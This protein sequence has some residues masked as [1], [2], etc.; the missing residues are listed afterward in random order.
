VEGSSDLVASAAYQPEAAA[1]AAARRFVRETLQSWLAAEHAPDGRGLVDDAVLLTSELVTNAV[2]HAGTPVQVTCKLADGGLEVMVRD[3]LPAS[4]VPG[5]AKDENV[6]AERTNG[7][8]LLLPSALASAWGV[9]YGRAA[10]AVWFRMGL[11][12]AGEDTSG[13]SQPGQSGAGQSGASQWRPARAAGSDYDKLLTRTV[14]S[15]RAALAADAAYALMPDEDG[16]LRVN[17][18]TGA[19]PAE[20]LAAWPSVLTAPF[21]VAGRV[22]GV[23]AVAGASP[24]QFAEGTAQQLQFLADQVAAPLERARLADIELLR[25]ARAGVAAEAN[26]LLAGPVDQDAILALAGRAVVPRLSAW[27][28]VLLARPDGTLQPV[29]VQHAE[30]SRCAALSWVVGRAGPVAP[31]DDHQPAGRSGPGRAWNLA[32]ADLSGAPPGAAELA[33]RGAWCV[34]LIARGRTLGLLA[35]GRPAAGKLPREAAQLA[36][37]LCRR[38]ALGLDSVRLAARQELTSEALRRTLVPPQMPR[39]PGIDLAVAHDLAAGGS[40]AGGDF[41]DVFSVGEGRWRFAVGEACGPQPEAAAVTSLARYALRILAREGHAIPAVLSRLNE[42][43]V[44]EGSPGRYLTLVHGEIVAG[45]PARISLACA[46]QP[47]PLLLRAPGESLPVGALPVGAQ[48]VDAQALGAQAVGTR[49][50]G[51]RSAVALSGVAGLTEERAVPERAALPQ[52]ILGVIEGLLFEAQ[53][54]QLAPGDLLLCV[55]DG[56]TRRRDGN[57]LLDDD[58]GLARL[59][60]GCAGLPADVVAAKVHEEVRSFGGRPAADGMALLAIRAT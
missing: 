49:G 8:G 11:A 28:A 36:E 3:S 42:L 37:D 48:T 56:V 50:V 9:T 20:L 46:G 30:E 27:C 10:K 57:R 59:L 4:L 51:A 25:K 17:A 39:I 45:S 60:A 14:E 5:P 44:D 47:L 19:D 29:Y 53:T 43:L 35:M 55:T 2:V 16:D 13:D 40:E 24:G 26:N 52:P 41:C 23:L 12:G 34:P 38:I 54:I 7:R 32:A 1:V 18:V 6:P 58:D 15:A 33:A 31:W 21:L 22:T